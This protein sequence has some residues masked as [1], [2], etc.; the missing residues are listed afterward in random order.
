ML[1]KKS[2]NDNDSRRHMTSRLPNCK[3]QQEI[4]ESSEIMTSTTLVEGDLKDT[5]YLQ[6]NIVDI[7]LSSMNFFLPVCHI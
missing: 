4:M 2:N 6:I 7:Q 1:I 3:F 5:I